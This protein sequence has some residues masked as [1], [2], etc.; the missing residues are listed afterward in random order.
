MA[1]FT[2]K[3]ADDTFGP[4]VEPISRG[5]FDFTLTFEE[6][7]FS[8]GPSALL[9]LIGT[10]RILY[11][12]KA[13]R[14]VARSSLVVGKIVSYTVRASGR[15]KADLVLASPSCSHSSTSCKPSIVGKDF[16][17]ADTSIYCCC[18]SVLHRHH[19]PSVSIIPRAR[20]VCPPKSHY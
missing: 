14:R 10:L 16:R 11:L 7:I 3:I 20:E 1:N 19:C 4:F 9:L 13:P 8:I 15:C 2:W 17:A 6:S 18:N 5:S 12:S